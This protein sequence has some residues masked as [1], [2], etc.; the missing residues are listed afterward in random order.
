MKVRATLALLAWRELKSNQFIRELK[1]PLKIKPRLV[2]K[3]TCTELL[4]LSE[5]FETKA[6]QILGLNLLKPISGNRT[7]IRS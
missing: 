7:N 4:L 3:N 1:T 5:G 2:V 6:T